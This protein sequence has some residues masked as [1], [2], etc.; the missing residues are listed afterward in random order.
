MTNQ[1]FIKALHALE[2]QYLNYTE[3]PTTI[4]MQVKFG[5]LYGISRN[6]IEMQ[7]M[8]YNRLEDNKKLYKRIR[9][10]IND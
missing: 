8:L 1:E 6:P 7:F 5:F 3:Y 2:L 10:M 4:T 9:K